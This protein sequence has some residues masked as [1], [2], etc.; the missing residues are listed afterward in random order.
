MEVVKKIIYSDNAFGKI[1]RKIVNKHVIPTIRKYRCFKYRNSKID[2][3]KIMFIT[4]QGFYTCNPK[5]IAEEI[6]K[7]NKD[8]KIVWCVR[9]NN[10]SDNC[11]YPKELI[12]VSRYSDEFYKELST[13]KIIIENSTNLAHCYYKKKKDQ[14]FIQTWHG[15]FGL[16]KSSPDAIKN[17]SWL[18]KAI[19]GGK[20]TDYCISNS[21][22]ENEYYKSTYWKDAEILEYGHPRNDILF[23]K[24]QEKV[25][26]LKKKIC[27][28]YNL[29][30]NTKI[31]LY[32]PTFR[33]K[34]TST[35]YDIDFKRLKNTL[36]KKFGGKWCIFM[37][38]HFNEKS[39]ISMYE[40]S[41]YLINVTL[42]DDIQELMLVADCGITD[43][44]SWICDFVLTKKPCFLYASD[45]NEYKDERGFYYPFSKTP[46]KLAKNNDELEK[47]ILKFDEKS[48][49]KKTKEYLDFVGC[50][51]NGTASK[52]VVDKIEEIIK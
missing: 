37:K 51:E 14:V 48:Y 40:S 15:S 38:L 30:I 17:K 36:E 4:F 33:D 52:K 11:D 22:F 12:K 28:L 9:K 50:F 23:E 10:D 47:I 20:M 46:F 8:Y 35:M 44:S 13:S 21:T 2:E 6:I 31:L 45:L 49:A 43:Y 16:K 34:K 25:L 42:Y 19:I 39:H 41:D 1:C 3:K 27:D 26:S 32:A 18:K 7:R 29:D 24:N 5:A